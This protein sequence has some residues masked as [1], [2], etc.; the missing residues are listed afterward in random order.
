VRVGEK[1]ALFGVDSARE[2]ESMGGGTN[3]GGDPRTMH[4]WERQHLDKDRG[5]IRMTNV[6]KRTCS[7]DSHAGGVHHLYVP[8]FA[9]GTD[10]PPANEIGSEK[11]DET[12]ASEQRKKRSVQEYNFQSGSEKHSS[13][14]QN[15]RSKNGI[16]HFGGTVSHH[17]A[18]VATGKVQFVKAQ[19]RYDKQE[20]EIGFNA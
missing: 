8:M 11:N 13:M 19:K 14:D 16:G 2:H 7:D 3:A 1:N 15:H 6:T 18:L 17:F 9:E 12:D 20:T 4:E 5:V 10:N